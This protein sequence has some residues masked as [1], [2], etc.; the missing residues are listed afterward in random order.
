M[1]QGNRRTIDDYAGFN[2]MVAVVLARRR[3][4]E[5][6]LT[7]LEKGIDPFMSNALEE[8]RQGA[9]EGG[10]PIGAALAD[11]EGRLVATGRKPPGPRPVGGD[12]RGDQLPPQS[13]EE[14]EQLPRHDHVFYPDA[15]PHV[16]RGN[17]PVRD[18]QG[19]CGGVGEL[20]GE[21]RPR[22]ATPARRRGG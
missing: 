11:T 19:H 7:D 2:D 14:R 22:P 4:K 15:V 21:Q 6:L 9:A 3:I 17:R 13:G 18:C 1:P 5:R 12:A 16:R 20:R 10:I 8:A